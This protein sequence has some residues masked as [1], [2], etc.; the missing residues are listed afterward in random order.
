VHPM[1]HAAMVAAR[2]ADV[3]RSA[4]RE[5]RRARMEPRRHASRRPARVALGM[6]LITLGLRLVDIGSRRRPRAWPALN[7]AGGLPVDPFGAGV[8]E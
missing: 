5:T 2:R 3:E 4:A 7:A 6:G 8:P 1:T